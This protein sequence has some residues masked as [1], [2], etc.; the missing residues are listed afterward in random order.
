MSRKVVTMLGISALCGVLAAWYAGVWLNDV[1]NVSQQPVTETPAM[2]TVLVASRDVE[3]GSIFDESMISAVEMPADQLPKG[4]ITAIE[5]VTGKFALRPFV[6]GEW[7]IP[8]RL[9]DSLL[10][11]LLAARI[12]PGKRAVSVSVDADAVSGVA[13]FVMPGD[14]VD[15]LSIYPDT[16]NSNS[17]GSE[18]LLQNMHVLAVDQQT[19]SK[20]GHPSLMNTV[21]FEATP[22]QAEILALADRVGSLQLILRNPGE[23]AETFRERK[24]LQ[25]LRGTEQ[26]LIQIIR[27]AQSSL[28]NTLTGS[29]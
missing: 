2:A 3:F 21:T 28:I 12:A 18:L 10:T 4:V 25:I 7:L 6:E 9:G 27:P 13:G 22:E 29:K 16:H 23:L 14:R 24:Q 1:Q 8:D 19:F 5:E 11:G 20:D 26:E 15:V 17:F